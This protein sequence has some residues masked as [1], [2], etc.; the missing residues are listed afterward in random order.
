MISAQNFMQL[1]SYVVEQ[2]DFGDN[3]A[4]LFEYYMQ[5]S[6]DFL[7]KDILSRIESLPEWIRPADYVQIFAKAW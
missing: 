1:Y 7:R 2:C 3:S 5:V 4:G 6:K